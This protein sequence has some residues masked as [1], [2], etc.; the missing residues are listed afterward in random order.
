MVYHLGTGHPCNLNL[1]QA[2]NFTIAD[3]AAAADLPTA[4]NFTRPDAGAAVRFV[5]NPDGV[6]FSWCSQDLEHDSD[7]L[8]AA[9]LRAQEVK[10][11]IGT[12]RDLGWR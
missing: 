7:I 11:L 4:M 9:N 2:M 6:S 12:F 3:R 5:K 10:V 8:M 1:I